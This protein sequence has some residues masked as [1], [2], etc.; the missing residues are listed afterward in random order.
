M[1]GLQDLQHSMNKRLKENE[2]DFEL[3]E[4]MKVEDREEEEQE[5]EEK[6]FR[7]KQTEIRNM[8]R[9]TE[10]KQIVNP[11]E[12]HYEKHTDLMHLIYESKESIRMPDNCKFHP[13]GIYS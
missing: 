10:A 3:I 12:E 6:L 8:K 9:Q 11:H 13:E 5:G 2:E 7:K 1:R 4:G